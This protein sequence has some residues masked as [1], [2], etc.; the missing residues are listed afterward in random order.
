M[1]YLRCIMCVKGPPEE[2]MDNAKRIEKSID[3]IENNLCDTLKLKEIAQESHFSEFHF[4]RLFRKAFGVSV[5]DYI[6]KKRLGRAA[7][8][9]TETHEKI[10]DI[11]LKYQFN[12]EEAFSRAFRKLYSMS[13][14]E[15][16]LNGKTPIRHIQTVKRIAPSKNN[17]GSSLMCKAA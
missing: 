6:R 10:T 8:E 9:L 11:A 12:S 14:R 16:R 13:P 1:F 7:E 3:Y 4:H 2:T 5:M 15:F 17:T